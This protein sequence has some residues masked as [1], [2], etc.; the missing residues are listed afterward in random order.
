M[1][2]QAAP[3][4]LKSQVVVGW[5]KETP[6]PNGAINNYLSVCD[7]QLFMDGLNLTQLILG[8]NLP[9]GL[10]QPLRSPLEI[11]YL[12][13]IPPQIASLRKVFEEVIAETGYGGRF[14]YAYASKANAAD[15]VVRTA[16]QT[17][18][19][20]EI[21]S[22]IDVDL[23]KIML[24]RGY[25][26]S[27]QMIICNGFKPTGSLYAHHILEL[28][29]LHGNVIPIV[30]DLAELP[31]LVNSGQSFEVGLRQ[32]SY[33]RH[34]DIAEM[35]DVNSQFGMQLT[36]IARAASQIADTPNLT[37][38]IY[39]A[40][41]GGQIDR[42]DDFVERLTPPI[43]I[44]AQLRQRHPDLTIFDFG[45]GI[46]APTALQFH[47][48]YHAFARLLLTTLQKNCKRCN[49]PEPDV[50]GEVGRYTVTDHGAHIFKVELVK[51]NKS[52]FPWYIING[53][54]MTSFPDTWALKKHFTVLPV[55]HLDQP[56]RR[57]QLG[58]LTCDSDDVYPPTGSASPLYLPADA[59]NLYVG[60]FGI[61]AYQEML[62]GMG[63]VKH[64]LIPEADELII[65]RTAEGK[66]TFRVNHGQSLREIAHTLGYRPE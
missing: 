33:G 35:N 5:E 65:D 30:D 9:E 51:E 17:G 37:L 39:H 56:F 62:G 46:P 27:Q 15:E 60:F 53:S 19:H 52:K 59:E 10:S 50:M 47:F 13:L 28:Q 31:F 58:G 45:G 21:S 36:D 48:D 64:C 44:Y 24:S 49:V 3:L 25:L 8:L 43:E 66:Y 11:V 41:V 54:I 32:K 6:I 14:L 61:G 23:I 12:P 55:T 20:F 2:H 18:V 42:E 16:L 57:V 63:G 7:G 38:R 4:H 29:R 26:T 22:Y 40:M 34:N 1:D